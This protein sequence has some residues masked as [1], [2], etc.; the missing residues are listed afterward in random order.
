MAAM[1][2]RR[3]TASGC[4]LGDRQDRALLDL[5]LQGVEPR[6]GQDDALGESYVEGG[7]RVHRLGQHFLGNA[8]HFRNF[9][10]ERLEIAVIGFD[11]MVAHWHFS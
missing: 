4:A 2:S 9:A 8:T 11:G 6:I 7:E 10:S 1:H 3:S 5:A